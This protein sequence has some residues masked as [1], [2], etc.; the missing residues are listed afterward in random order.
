MASDEKRVILAGKW[1]TWLNG[2][3]LAVKEMKREEVTT[4]WL[5]QELGLGGCP[6]ALR[7][8]FDSRVAE[9]CLASR[10]RS[11]KSFSDLALSPRPPSKPSSPSPQPLS[12]DY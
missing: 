10:P 5:E 1:A 11:I 12:A 2:G 3:R 8:D 7:F 4:E 6:E 9:A